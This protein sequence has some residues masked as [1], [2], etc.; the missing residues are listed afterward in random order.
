[1]KSVVSTFASIALLAVG[2]SAHAEIVNIPASAGM[3]GSNPNNQCSVSLGSFGVSNQAPAAACA[4]EVPIS[5]PAGR[6]VLQ[7]D[8]IHSTNSNCANPYVEAALWSVDYSTSLPTI[9]FP[10]SSSAYVTPD[11]KMQA[12]HLMAQVAG[13]KTTLYPDAF[14]VQAKTMYN[15]VATVENCASVAGL[16]V[17]YQ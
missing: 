3:Q 9:S 12:T 8:V 11:G 16:Q 6:T 17:T 15:V 13:P 1:M 5:V 2:I 14:V 10:W 4:F 7:I